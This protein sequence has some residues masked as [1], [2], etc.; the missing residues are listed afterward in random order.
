MNKDFI[1]FKNLLIKSASNEIS[2]AD[3]LLTIEWRDK[4]D[5][6]LK[7]DQYRCTYCGQEATSAYYHTDLRKVMHI[8]ISDEKLHT[9]ETHEGTSNREFLPE[10]GVS[11][12]PYV[13][14]IHHKHYVINKLPWEY[15]NRDL[16]TLC[17]WCHE[18]IHSNEEM[19]VYFE[20]GDYHSKLNACPRCQG[21]G[22]IPEYVHIQGGICFNC[23]GSGFEVPVVKIK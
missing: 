18:E 15:N 9:V 3:L 13:L 8:R 23:W 4:R 17:N 22:W 10:I 11:E 6:I 7:R 2:Y 12:K 21:G 5:E 1:S 14:H 16:I 19:E 20:N